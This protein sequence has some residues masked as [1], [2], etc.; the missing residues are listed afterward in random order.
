M[1]E[2]ATILI[3][4]RDAA[5]TIGRAVASAVAQGDFPIVLVDHHSSDGTSG[6]ALR[7]ARDRLRIV[8]APDRSTLGA[9]RAIALDSAQTRFAVWLDAD[10]ELLPGRVPAMVE[11]LRRSGADLVAD[12]AEIVDGPA[13]VS[14]GIAPIPAFLFGRHPLAR[15]FERMYL[16]GPGVTGMRVEFARRIGF[17]SAFHGAEDLD[18]LLRAIAGGARFELLE[19]A[20]YRLYAFPSS[21]SRDIPNQREMYRR[22]LSKHTYDAVRL[23]YRHAGWE[24]AIAAWALVSVATFRED[25]ASAL[26]FLDE[27]ESLVADQTRVIEPEGPYPLP[28]AWR[29][30]FAR[31]TIQLLLGR[32]EEATV[33]LSRAH[34]TLVTPEGL[35]NLGVALAASRRISEA[36]ALFGESLSLSPD[37]LDARINLASTSPN[38]ITRLPLRRLPAR[39]D[40]QNAP[41]GSRKD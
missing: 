40:Y 16:P 9:V 14:R 34:S 41:N 39:S 22:A 19:S 29:V 23:L 20:G 3:V 5:A 27:A 28:E 24:T 17:D 2:E 37:Y 6:I 13:G 31:G 30:S 35:N 11:S 26:E 21:L 33:R 7:A 10:D 36:K 15:L 12:A 18:F 32:V 4:A 25:Y 8:R 1:T 38:R